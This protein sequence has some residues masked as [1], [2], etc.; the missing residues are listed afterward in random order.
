MPINQTLEEMFMIRE[1][2]LLDV[3]YDVLEE[4]EAKAT[5][6][7]ND[8]GD[9]ADLFKHLILDVAG[10]QFEYMYNELRVTYKALWLGITE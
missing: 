5:A 7:G 2:Q 8:M 10:E 4:A 1:E 3:Y 6:E 9:Y